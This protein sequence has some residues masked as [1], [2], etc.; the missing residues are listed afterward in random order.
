[1]GSAPPGGA[2]CVAGALGLVQHDDAEGRVPQAQLAQPLAQHR[3]GAHDDGRPELARVVQPR[4]ER[5]H[6]RQQKLRF[7]VLG[8]WEFRV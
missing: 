5:R 7:R 8:F 6:L 3:R 1:M 4:Q 2:L